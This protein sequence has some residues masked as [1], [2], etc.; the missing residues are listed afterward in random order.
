[1]HDDGFL[2]RETLQRSQSVPDSDEH[3]LD[4]YA[5]THIHPNTNLSTNVFII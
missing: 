3:R 4:M 2:Q 1:M 5:L